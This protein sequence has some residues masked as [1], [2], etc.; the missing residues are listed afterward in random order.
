MACFPPSG[1]QEQF[2]C[3]N[4]RG[5]LK[6]VDGT[7]RMPAPKNLMDMLADLQSADKDG[8]RQCEILDAFQAS[9][10]VTLDFVVNVGGKVVKALRG[11]ADEAV[12][13][14]AIALTAHWK[15]LVKGKLEDKGKGKGIGKD[16]GKA[17]EETKGGDEEMVTEDGEAPAVEQC[18]MRTECAPA[19]R[20]ATHRLPARLR[21]SSCGGRQQPNPHR[22]ASTGSAA[23]GRRPAFRAVPLLVMAASILLLTARVGSYPPSHHFFAAGA[24]GAVRPVSSP[25]KIPASGQL[26]RPRE[27]VVLKGDGKVVH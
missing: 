6:G 18:V 7:S 15:D 16:K 13:K 26:A 2:A 11:S 8:A 12:R 27:G 23:Q 3:K 10:D 22:K 9:S 17:E 14:R 20:C 5:S 21:V 4:S 24:G 19:S 25:S 1:I